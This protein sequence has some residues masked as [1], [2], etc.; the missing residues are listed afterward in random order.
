MSGKIIRFGELSKKLFLPF[1]MAIGQVLVNIN[2]KFYP[3]ETHAMVPELFAIA[4]GAMGIKFVPFIIKVSSKDEKSE[5][6]IKN[7]KFYH[8]IILCVIF[9][10]FTGMRAGYG[11][12][13]GNF[14][15]ESHQ[16]LN[17]F[18]DGEFLKIGLQ[19]IAMMGISILFLK[20]KYYLHHYIA[21]AIF[22]ILGI[23]CDFS[24][25]YY[26]TLFDNIPAFIMDYLTIPIDC[27]QYYYQKYMMEKL[28]FPYW[29]V[30]FAPGLMIF[31]YAFSLLMVT[32]VNPDK[33]DSS[34]G[35]VHS[36]YLYFE[37]NSPGIIFG[38]LFITF[39]LYSVIYIFS[40]LNNY[41]YN[42]NYILI[43]CH[44]SKIT[45]V[46]LEESPKDY[47]CIV[48]FIG[49]IFNMLIFLEILEL[50]FCQ[51][52]YN[53]KRNIYLRGSIDISGD[54]G[55]DSTLDINIV[56]VNKYYFIEV[57]KEDNEKG[58]IELYDQTD[59][60]DKEENKID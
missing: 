50:D 60:E 29:N 18:S 53:T 2:N 5:E 20:Y 44:L 9:Q 37:K 13:I 19:M 30:G 26:D 23:A 55:R 58:S 36:F 27:M 11:Y 8:Y 24:L 40:I 46:F 45:Q 35:F 32:L 59:E 39:V 38:K 15:K 34:L 41:Y 3:E 12:L 10:M 1:I 49:Q 47:Y 17:P 56:D 54:C 21:I 14:S 52:N 7:R 25:R 48:F 42:P 28:Y 6:K 16:V 31:G 51:L 57:K 43:G 22:I 33:I 4:F